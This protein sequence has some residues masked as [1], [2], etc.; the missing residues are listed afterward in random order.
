MNRR[1]SLSGEGAPDAFRRPKRSPDHLSHGMTLPTLPKR[2]RMSQDLGD[3][4]AVH[5]YVLLAA[6]DVLHVPVERLLSIAE[7]PSSSDIFE[8]SSSTS[9]NDHGHGS[10]PPDSSG[11]ERTSHVVRSRLV[12]RPKAHPAFHQGHT[13]LATHGKAF[14]GGV[15]NFMSD[16]LFENLDTEPLDD[17]FAT[18]EPTPAMSQDSGI[19]MGDSNIWPESSVSEFSFTSYD[20]QTTG[21]Q[22]TTLLPTVGPLAGMDDFSFSNYAEIPF[23]MNQSL[24]DLNELNYSN[25][26][27]N[28]APSNA[29][30][31]NVDLFALNPGVQSDLKSFPKESGS[32][33]RRRGPFRAEEQRQETGL[34]RKLGACIRCSLHRIRCIPDPNSPSGCCKTCTQASHTKARW[35]PCLRYKIIDAELLAHD[36][37]PRPTWTTRWKKMELVD[38]STWASNSIKS[39]QCTQD[40]GNTSYT[41]QVR[42][43]KP[44]EGDALSRRWKIDG[45]PYT[46]NCTNYAV[47]DMR[48]AGKTLMQFAKQS[49]PVAINHWVDGQ[50]SLLRHTYNMAYSYSIDAGLRNEDREL[51]S[52][53][54]QLWAASRMMSKAAHI[55]GRET[56]GMTRQDFGPKSASTNK[57]LMPP[58]F[59]AQ[60]EVIFVTMMLQPLKKEIL[61]RLKVLVGE[62]NRRSWLAIYLCIFLLLHSCA[63]LTARDRER[64]VMQGFPLRFYRPRVIDEIHNGAKILLAYFHF[65]NR[66]SFPLHMDWTS[67]DQIALAE[68]KP[69]QIKFMQNNV[70]EYEKKS[71]HFRH[72]LE[73]KI[74]E[75]EF[76]FIAQLY[77]KDWK[78]RHTV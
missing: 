15:D 37:C 51:L 73:N 27:W 41:L 17:L 56:L 44:I 71:S 48:E 70:K 46:Y 76:Y 9:S 77:E 43:F 12:R 1:S 39:I 53:T 66:G 65:C 55:C 11:S 29:I 20:P 21:H 61:D 35:L 72:I 40:V 54:L 28:V 36:V 75:D 52:A 69:E 57:I 64:A 7:S 4:N 26:S 50:D 30:R 74:Y 34:T 25:G 3:Y 23:Q 49:L 13:S 22:S 45:I 42:E 38:I 19:E 67:A 5:Q 32:K 31:P 33:G 60:M 14:T 78:P 62:N 2:K 47:A 6:A 16:Q 59:S 63:L 68:L 10:T 58:V 8:T 24:Q 18:E